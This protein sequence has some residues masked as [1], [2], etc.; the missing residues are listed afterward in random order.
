MMR[1]SPVADCLSRFRLDG[2]VRA[3]LWAV[4]ACAVAPACAN[5]DQTPAAQPGAVA[6]KVL[7]VSGSVKVGAKQLA[8]GDAVKTDDVIETGADGNVVIELAHNQARWELGPGHKVRPT[9]SVA[10]TQERHGSAGVVDQDTSAAGR[11][12]ERSAADTATS[13]K[14]GERTDTAGA[15]PP[16][17]QPAPAAA[18]APIAPSAAAPSRGAVAAPHASASNAPAPPPP[19]P[20]SPTDRETQAAGDGLV[21]GGAAPGGGGGGGRSRGAVES[22]GPLTADMFVKLSTCVPAGSRVEVKIHVAK[23]VPAITFE[24]DADAAV[25]QCITDAANKLTLAVASGDVVLTL[26]R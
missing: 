14:A 18:T 13:A 19:P 8:V 25:K 11:P 9:E 10:W 4:L 16:S 2:M 6:G 15:P 26:R 1:A 5:K 23:H 22:N 12:A 7:E 3:A 17:A 20:P 24:G 21:P